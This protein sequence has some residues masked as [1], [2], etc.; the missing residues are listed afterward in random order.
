MYEKLILN[1]KEGEKPFKICKSFFFRYLIYFMPN[2]FFRGV[3][4]KNK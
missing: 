4:L 3:N 1:E 2:R